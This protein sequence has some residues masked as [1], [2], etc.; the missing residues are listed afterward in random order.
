MKYVTPCA[1]VWIEIDLIGSL[2]SALG[3][4]PCAGVWIEMFAD[5]LKNEEED[6]H[7]LCGSV[8]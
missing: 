3:V 6:G 5:L 4:T 1:G 2:F 8:D 7:S